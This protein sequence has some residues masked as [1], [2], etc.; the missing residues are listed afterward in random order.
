MNECGRQQTW[1]LFET[2]SDE[3]KEELVCGH[4]IK[5]VGVYI[6]RHVVLFAWYGAFMKVLAKKRAYHRWARAIKCHQ[7][8][9]D[10]CNSI[11]KGLLEEDC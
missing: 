6:R 8:Y 4:N 5:S 1:Y 10:I 2:K 9:I 11:A 3:K 7:V